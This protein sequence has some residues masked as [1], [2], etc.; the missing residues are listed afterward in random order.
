MTERNR[1]RI[2]YNDLCVANNGQPPINRLHA[3]KIVAGIVKAYGFSKTATEGLARDIQ[4]N[5][6][7]DGEVLP[8]FVILVC[9]DEQPWEF[10]PED[11]NETSEDYRELMMKLSVHIEAIHELIIDAWKNDN[12]ITYVE[13]HDVNTSMNNDVSA[14]VTKLLI[15]KCVNEMVNQ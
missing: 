5:D 8:S 7:L 11:Y 10:N 3:S 4:I 13:W 14:S 12:E 6:N 1:L 9:T 2:T 15:D